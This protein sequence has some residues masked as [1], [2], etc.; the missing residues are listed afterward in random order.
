MATANSDA[1][2]FTRRWEAVAKVVAPLAALT[3]IAYFVSWQRTMALYWEFGIDSSVL[4][5]T[6]TDYLLRSVDVLTRVVPYGLLLI[7]IVAFAFVFVLKQDLR[8][9]AWTAIPVGFLL[10]IGAFIWDNSRYGAPFSNVFPSVIF[11]VGVLVGWLGLA[12]LRRGE[13]LGFF[14]KSDF[15]TVTMSVAM[16]LL[17]FVGVMATAGH[18]ARSLG[19]DQ[20]KRIEQSVP[21]LPSV[22]LLSPIPLFDSWPSV[23]VTTVADEP[24]L[25]SH[26]NL[27]LLVHADGR[28]LVFP[29]DQS[30][31]DGVSVING[32]TVQVTFEPG[33]SVDTQVWN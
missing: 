5:F 11:T 24:P 15:L 26:R 14:G 13:H 21:Q 17:L 1:S 16:G 23:D 3:A 4:G 20:A 31:R 33:V 7:S 6:T 22:T 9:L 12:L 25:F 30:P 8:G 10:T 28:Y 2:D 27:K 29:A 32:D 19:R 18:Y